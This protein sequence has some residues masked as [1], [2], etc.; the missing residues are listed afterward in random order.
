LPQQESK[1]VS[2]L[3]TLPTI[4]DFVIDHLMHASSMEDWDYILYLQTTQTGALINDILPG[5]SKTVLRYK[6]NL[7]K[8]ILNKKALFI[9]CVSDD[10]PLVV[11]MI[12]LAIDRKNI[13]TLDIA[14][15]SGHEAQLFGVNPLYDNA[16]EPLL[17]SMH[18]GL[19]V[20]N[21]VQMLSMS[22]Q[23][24][25]AAYIRYGHFTK[26]ESNTLL[27]SDVQILLASPLPLLDTQQYSNE[28]QAILKE[29]HITVACPA[30]LDE[31]DFLELVDGYSAQIIKKMGIMHFFTLSEYDKKM[32]VT[33]RPSSLTELKKKL[34]LLITRSKSMCTDEALVRVAQLGKNALKDRTSMSLLWH[35]FNK[36]QNKIATFLGVNRSSVNRKIKMF[37]F[38]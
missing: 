23:D 29:Q 11:N 9:E 18:L 16:Q 1:Q 15:H 36:N 24:K 33:H 31:K 27:S 14:H 6:I 13:F 7:L 20:L 25:L 3:I 8:G 4:S 30:I 5:W 32:L 38:S 26:L 12:H 37:G 17:L 22:A 35:A 34:F 19:L 2:L 21:N 10:L 28:L